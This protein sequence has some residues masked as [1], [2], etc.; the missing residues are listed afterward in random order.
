MSR[1]GEHKPRW[2]T[3]NEEVGKAWY[4]ELKYLWASIKTEVSIP[5]PNLTFAEG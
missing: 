4:L 3:D 1:E 2:D 5:D